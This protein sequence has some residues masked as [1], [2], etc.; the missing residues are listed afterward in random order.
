MLLIFPI[1]KPWSHV[2]YLTYDLYEYYFTLAIGGAAIS[3]YSKPL[4]STAFN[5]HKIPSRDDPKA[6]Q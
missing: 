1:C 5:V 4:S 6:A 3:S 2:P